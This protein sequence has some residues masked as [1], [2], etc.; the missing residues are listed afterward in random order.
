MT[1]NIGIPAEYA[2]PFEKLVNSHPDRQI[3]IKTTKAHPVC[4]LLQVT[5]PV[6]QQEFF[7]NLLNHF[8][9]KHGQELKHI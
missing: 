6:D 1:Y 7:K 5:F 3:S 4:S 8:S 9:E 2:K